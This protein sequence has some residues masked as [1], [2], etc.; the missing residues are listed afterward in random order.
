MNPTAE[1]S[2]DALHDALVLPRAAR[3]DRRVAKALLVERG[4]LSSAD[5]RLIEAGLERL[6]WRATLKPAT[7]G[8]RAFADEARDYAGIVVMAAAFRPGAKAARLT[9][10]IHRAIAHP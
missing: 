3:V 5:R 6:T 9:E 7:A 10:V 2:S 1:A 4:G 8:L